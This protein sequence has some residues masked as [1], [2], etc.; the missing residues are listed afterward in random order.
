MLLTIILLKSKALFTTKFNK[1]PDNN[2]GEVGY[3]NVYHLK[4]VV[5]DGEKSIPFKRRNF[6]KIMLVIGE[7]TGHY[8]DKIVKVQK[9]A[10]SFSNPMIPY[11]L[12]KKLKSCSN[13]IIGMSHKL[14]LLWDLKR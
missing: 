9:Q 14:P 12:C 5:T 1:M 7:G 6:F 10:L 4:S 3:F 8:A 2:H 13:T 11:G